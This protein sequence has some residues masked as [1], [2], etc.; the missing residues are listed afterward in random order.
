MKTNLDKMFNDAFLELPAKFSSEVI[1]EHLGLTKKQAT[2]KLKH[3]GVRRTRTG[4]TTCI[5]YNPLSDMAGLGQELAAALGYGKVA[6][7]QRARPVLF[8]RAR[9]TEK[10]IG[11]VA[12]LTGAS[13]IENYPQTLDFRQ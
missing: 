11:M 4:K 3:L 12:H 6:V 7:S 2:S 1:A 9:P 13:N 10:T 5:W 8:T